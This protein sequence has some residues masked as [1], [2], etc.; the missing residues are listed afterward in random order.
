VLHGWRLPTESGVRCMFLRR[1]VAELHAGTRYAS[2]FQ[3]RKVA[4]EWISGRAITPQGTPLLSAEW[5]H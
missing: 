1:C 5:F 2:D 3:Q 4:K